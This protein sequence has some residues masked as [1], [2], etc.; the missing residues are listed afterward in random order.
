MLEL[1]PPQ[2]HGEAPVELVVMEAL[3]GKEPDVPD[4]EVA[5][6]VSEVV[7]ALHGVEPPAV[8]GPADWTAFVAQ[9]R[10]A[11][12]EQQRKRGL[13]EWWLERIPEFPRGVDLGAE[14]AVRLRTGGARG[15]RVRVRG[16]RRLRDETR[17]PVLAGVGRG[18]RARS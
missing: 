2:F 11:C 16:R 13:G 4:V 12:V 6:R 14:R 3:H 9:R 7:R 1:F 10:S 18:V 5:A 17:S 15:V 8:L